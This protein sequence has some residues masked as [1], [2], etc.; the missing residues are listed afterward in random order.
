MK[1]KTKLFVFT[2]SLSFSLALLTSLL[3]YLDSSRQKFEDLRKEITALARAAALLV[4]EPAH[5][6]LA[7]SMDASSPEYREIW[8][9][10]S[11]FT[12]TNPKI[13]YVY[14]MV[15]S[16][17]PGIW[18]FVVDAD[19]KEDL[20][21]DGVISDDEIPAP[22]GEQY[23][24]T[25]Y[26]EMR[27]AFEG[28]LADS[29][30]D[31]DKWGWVL[32]A[33]A[34]ILDADG[35]ATAI[36]G[37]D[38]SADTIM[39][40]RESLKTRIALIFA[41]TL[42]VSLILSSVLAD[43][44]T[45]PLLK[46]IEA[47]RAIAAGD[48]VTLPKAR[49]RDEIGLLLGSIDT[50]SQSIKTTIDKLR[51]LNR[52]AEI[53]KLTLDLDEA[54]KLSVNLSLEVLGASRAA[55]LL[56]DEKE[57]R[58]L[59]GALSG[60]EGATVLEGAILVGE[61]R[62]DLVPQLA[63][64]EKMAR[65][66][67]LHGAAGLRDDPDLAFFAA[68]LEATATTVFSPLIV[69]GEPRGAVLLDAGIADED[70]AL[71]F[72]G[73]VGLS[74][75][76]ARLYHEAIADGL[77]RLYVHR[78]FQV[79]LSAEVRRSRRYERDFSL[80]MIDLDHFKNVNDTHG[81]PAGDAVLRHVAALVRQTLRATDVP[82]RYGGEEFTV[83]LPE[84]G[85]EHAEKV[86]EK[87]RATIQESPTAYKDVSIPMTVSI[88]VATWSHETPVAPETLISR[89]DESVYRAKTEG[90]NRVCVFGSS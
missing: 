87:I 35:K 6:R 22:P 24:V 38:V 28:P 18:L 12:A 29:R 3:F 25:P 10:L 72:L 66:P 33:Y 69:K 8:T 63:Q 30:I 15:K 79:Q 41:A 76:N 44:F 53:L 13:L 16:P 45:K 21:G 62:L 80:L 17:R 54:L 19:I 26:P 64:V 75:E 49:R 77:T 20:D 5:T 56:Y 84:T 58:F 88:G 1:I 81:H 89:A 55:I 67:G 32:S 68:W 71:A 47:A 46:V 90:R 9:T 23:D 52:T 65:H 2:F 34:P 39:K 37:I 59:P 7:G 40:E 70:Y 60:I 85:R 48:F 42:L 50:M 43:S 78:Y 51:T 83:I 36:V 11:R 82:S 86:A 27:H 4:D 14:T 73:Q 31:R 61:R 57:N 74:L